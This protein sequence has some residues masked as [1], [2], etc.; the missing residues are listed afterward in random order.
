MK[1]KSTA[2]KAAKPA[3]ASHLLS[4]IHEWGHPEWIVIAVEAP[5]DQVSSHY[6]TIRSARKRLTEVP[7][8]ARRKRD[9]EI[10]PLVAIVQPK[11]SAWSVILRILCMPIGMPDVTD[12]EQVC[13][14]TSAKLKT[15]A[16]AF[17]GEDT[18]FAMGYILYQKGK[19]VGSKDWES[20][21][22][23]A[24]KAFADLG[25]YL[26]ACYPRQEG[27]KIWVCTDESSR[28]LIE[29]ADVVDIGDI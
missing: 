28:D 25:I 21:R 3:A 11:G 1:E 6:S 27:K 24:D 12:A 10:A 20:Q 7:I 19:K 29:R 17:I 26:P 18:S 14:K 5:V 15:R 4:F 23:S 2:S 22:N 9:D 8:H 13:Q 16:L